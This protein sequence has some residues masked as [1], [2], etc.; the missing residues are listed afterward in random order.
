MTTEEAVHV[1]SSMEEKVLFSLTTGAVA[2]WKWCTDNE[3]VNFI[4]FLII[5]FLFSGSF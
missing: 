4:I 3:E 1:S 5:I 2:C